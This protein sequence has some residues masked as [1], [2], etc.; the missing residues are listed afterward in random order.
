MGDPIMTPARRSLAFVD[1]LPSLKTVKQ[2]TFGI[3]PPGRVV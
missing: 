3:E 2:Y 1:P